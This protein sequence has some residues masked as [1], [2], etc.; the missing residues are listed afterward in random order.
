MAAG[1]YA[2]SESTETT[3]CYMRRC[4]CCV[5]PTHLYICGFDRTYAL[6]FDTSRFL[7]VL[8][9]AMRIAML[10]VLIVAH[11]DFK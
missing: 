5:E 7:I 3:C 9:I 8:R 6:Y 4:S 10:A 11:L 2:L 1:R